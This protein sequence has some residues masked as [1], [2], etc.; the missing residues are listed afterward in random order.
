[1]GQSE[2]PGG[3]GGWRGGKGC[4]ANMYVWVFVGGGGGGGEWGAEKRS[5]GGCRLSTQAKK[6]KLMNPLT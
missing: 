2:T 6:S 3:S 1:M 4:G 5:R